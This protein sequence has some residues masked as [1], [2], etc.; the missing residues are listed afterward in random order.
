MPLKRAIRL[1]G[2]SLIKGRI[3]VLS[4]FS[5]LNELWGSRSNGGMSDAR[6][7]S[8]LRIPLFATSSGGIG[9]GD[10]GCGNIEEA[11]LSSRRA[12]RGLVN[13]RVDAPLATNE[14]PGS[15]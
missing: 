15:I 5:P 8:R 14:A 9:R 2:R 3:V 1:A 6:E 11:M 4:N 7:R 10:S 13:S 12:P